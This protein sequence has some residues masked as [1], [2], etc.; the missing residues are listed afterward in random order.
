MKLKIT[1]ATNVKPEVKSSVINVLKKK[2]SDRKARKINKAEMKDYNF[3]H[4]N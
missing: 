3:F 4:S 2:M 1:T